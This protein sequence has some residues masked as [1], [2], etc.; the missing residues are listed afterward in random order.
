MGC[1]VSLWKYAIAIPTSPEK[2]RKLMSVG[3]PVSN[4][5]AT[6]TEFVYNPPTTQQ[7]R[8]QSYHIQHYRLVRLFN[9]RQPRSGMAGHKYYLRRCPSLQK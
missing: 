1:Q 6:A 8:A 7:L 4:L 2:K 9:I 5:S 3:K